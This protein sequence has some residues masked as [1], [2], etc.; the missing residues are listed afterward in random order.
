MEELGDAGRTVRAGE[1]E[2]FTVQHAGGEFVGVGVESGVG[3]A[4]GGDPDEP[5]CFGL[6]DLLAFGADRGEDLGSFGGHLWS[7]PLICYIQ[8]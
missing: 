7:P 1:H 8:H 6:G 3:V 4:G 5:V 2:L